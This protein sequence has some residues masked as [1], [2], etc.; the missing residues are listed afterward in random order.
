MHLIRLTSIWFKWRK[1]RTVS[2]THK[3]SVWKCS[4]FWFGG[5]FDQG[6]NSRIGI[7]DGNDSFFFWWFML[8][9]AYLTIWIWSFC[10]FL[11]YKCKCISFHMKIKASRYHFTFKKIIHIHQ[12]SQPWNLPDNPTNPLSIRQTGKTIQ[13]THLKWSLF[14][15][16][17]IDLD[18]E[19]FLLNHP[20]IVSQCKISHFTKIPKINFHAWSKMLLTTS[21]YR[22]TFFFCKHV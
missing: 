5:L 18:L 4:L 2:H 14:P 21:S 1:T 15:V 12:H 17:A 11:C 10:H 20:T 3:F 8:D 6:L 22:N 19:P 16:I 13:Q 7:N 9:N